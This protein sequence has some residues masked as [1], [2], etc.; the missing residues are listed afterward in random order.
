MFFAIGLLVVAAGV[1]TG[2]FYYKSKQAQP[3]SP[4]ISPLEA[5]TPVLQP[6]QK[7]ADIPISS[8][9]LYHV[10]AASTGSMSYEKTVGLKIEVNKTATLRMTEEESKHM[11]AGDYVL[12]MDKKGNVVEAIGEITTIGKPLGAQAQ[13][14]VDVIIAFSALDEGIISSITQGRIY[15]QDKNANAARLPKE[16]IINGDDGQDYVWELDKIV[17]DS[18]TIKKTS[19]GVTA[20]S[21]FYVAISPVFGGTNIYILNPDRT[22]REGSRILYDKSEPFNPVYKTPAGDQAHRV[23]EVVQQ[24][25]KED[26]EDYIL[27]RPGG[28]TQAA[29]PQP[30]PPAEGTQTGAAADVQP[31]A[32]SCSGGAEECKV[33]TPPPGSV[34]LPAPMPDPLPVH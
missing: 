30:A 28:Y 29:P 25:Q 1:F 5:M 14:T 32:S 6:P 12:P 13:D 9:T 7:M 10:S 31:P 19:A 33:W 3:V 24:K 23:L 17:N 22:L 27:T 26:L 15:S 16:A 8:D 11:A 4:V 21:E 2:L 20:R 18:A 34:Q